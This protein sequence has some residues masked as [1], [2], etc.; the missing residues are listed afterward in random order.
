MH[1]FI[2]LLIRGPTK[3]DTKSFM[4]VSCVFSVQINSNQYGNEIMH[5]DCSA[6]SII[7][8]FLFI[9]ICTVVDVDNRFFCTLH[10]PTLFIAYK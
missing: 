4:C 10:H 5:I 7:F 3:A 2:T 8:F 1:N 9:V 6:C